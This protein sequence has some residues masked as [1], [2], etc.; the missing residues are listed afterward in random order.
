MAKKNKEDL[1]LAE[2]QEETIP[3]DEKSAKE[4]KK[5]K[6]SKLKA[7]LHSRK[8]SRGWL[9]IGIIAVFLACVVAVNII[10]SVLES[11]FPALSFDITSSNM[12]HLQDDTKKLCESVDQDITIYL[13]VEEEAFTSY[14]SMY[15]VAYFTQANQFF[16]EIAE[17]NS[18][19]TFKYEDLSSN[20][21]FASNYSDLNLNTSG[22]GI[23]C[24][25]DAGDGR[26]QGLEFGDLFATEYDESTGSSTIT[27]STVEQAV[28]TSI[29]GLTK[30][31]A[32]KAC[33]ITSSGIA[34]EKDS[35]D[36]T[37]QYS[38]LKKLME[39]Q[40]YETTT[41][42]LDSQEKIPNDCDVLLFI[43]PT[44]DISEQGL[45]KINSFLDS[46]KKTNKTFF[47]I[48]S[49][50]EDENGTPL[51]DSFL[52]EQGIKV[53]K[54]FVYEQDN[55]YISSIYQNDHSLSAYDYNDEEFTDGIDTSKK[56]LMGN[57]RPLTLTEGSNAV[58][59][60]DTSDSADLFP[61]TAESEEDIV[62]G[63]GK[64]LCG[65]A[66]NKSEVK[67]G[68]YKN[69]VVV[70][71]YYAVSD[72]FL[73]QYTQ[74]NNANYFANM[75]NILTDNEGEAISIVS[76][77]AS[78]TALGIE[79][80]SQVTAPKIIF[81]FVLPIGILILGIVIWALRRKK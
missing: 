1:L 70:G 19:I 29:L 8:F 59:L 44:S 74:Y 9:S 17:L 65:G 75:F 47:Y 31:N 10:A 58:S 23:I 73:T 3:A 7:V 13:L 80:A 22:A 30:K 67:D 68:V 35:T 60:L 42:D 78:D 55:S 24:I 66:I 50:F 11:K 49:P 43:A 72:I 36:G 34:N 18:H 20:P 27:S 21:S 15:G 16:K 28:C 64:A 81:M 71:S 4:K 53:E 62:D 33:F 48:P 26:H 69:V 77:T 52:E 54:S 38:A 25:V 12:Y 57:T 79:T 76:A 6:E 41:V 63:G 2:T 51:M 45:E 46:A 56:V 5:N 32:A 61:F 14:D 39:N 37:S 40:A